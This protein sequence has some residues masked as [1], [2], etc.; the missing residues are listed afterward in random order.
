MELRVRVMSIVLSLT[1]SLT[2]SLAIANAYNISMLSAQYSTF[3]FVVS[4]LRP[5]TPGR[6]TLMAL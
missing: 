3:N 6:A 5:Q 1:H 4:G 2:H